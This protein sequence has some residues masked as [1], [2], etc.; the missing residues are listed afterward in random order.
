[1][2]RK[3][4]GK[5]PVKAATKPP[6][7]RKRLK[8]VRFHGQSPALGDHA[9]DREKVRF[10]VSSMADTRGTLSRILRGYLKG[11]FSEREVRIMVYGLRAV[12]AMHAEEDARD[13]DARLTA[14]EEK[15]R[16]GGQ[17]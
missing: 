13:L 4:A 6:K 11:T 3:R 14:L 12:A 8:A 17:T 15:L 9:G 5:H 16:R 2:Q 1:V 10:M 7:G